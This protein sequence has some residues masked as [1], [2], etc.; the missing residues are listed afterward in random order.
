MDKTYLIDLNSALTM[1]AI[2]DLRNQLHHH[3]YAGSPFPLTLATEQSG[4]IAAMKSQPQTLER[5]GTQG[6]RSPGKHWQEL[7]FLGPMEGGPFGLWAETGTIT[8]I[9]VG[10]RLRH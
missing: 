3:N 4:G 6:T 1:E 2:L 8:L 5:A 7:G 9:S 10:N